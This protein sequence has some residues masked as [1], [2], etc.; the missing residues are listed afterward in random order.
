MAKVVSIFAL[1][2]IIKSVGYSD[3]ILSNQG[4][5]FERCVK[6]KYRFQPLHQK[7]NLTHSKMFHQFRLV[8]E[9]VWRRRESL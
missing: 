9:M 3:K 5:S 1:L 8:M 2:S 6:S 7:I 4:L